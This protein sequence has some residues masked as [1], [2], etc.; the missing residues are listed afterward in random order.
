M[1][2]LHGVEDSIS[3]SLTSLRSKSSKTHIFMQ[4]V[5]LLWPPAFFSKNILYNL[6]NA[7]NKFFMLLPVAAMMMT[8]SFAQT[9]GVGPIL[10]IEGGQVQGIAT[11]NAG[12]TVYKGIPYAA[13]P[14]GNLR[15]KEPQPVKAW[16]GVKLC[17]RF[18]HPGY[19]SVHYPGGY[20]T[21]WGYGDEAPYSEDCLYLN[22]YTKAAGNP[23]KK[24]PVAL[25][26]HGG[27]YM[28]GWGTEPE[29]DGQEWASKDVV[30]VTINYRLGIFG[31]MTHPELS[32]ES[33]HHVSG[34]YGILDQI[35]SLKWIKANIEKFGGDSNN[36]TIFGQSAGAGSVRTICESPLA[37]GLFH[38]A[39]IMSGGGIDVPGKNGQAPKL[40]TPMA[41]FFTYNPS[42]QESE[43]ETKKVM[44]WAGLTSLRDLRK[45]STEML[46]SLPAIYNRV[47]K[48]DTYV[49]QRPIVDGYVSLKS[50]DKATREGTIADVP[51]MIGYTLNDMGNMSD[52]IAEFCKVRNAG[53]NKAWAYEFARPLP[54]DGSMPE[55]SARLSG[56]FHSSDLWYVFKSL[57][58]CW[59][60]WTK[61]DWDLSEKMLTAWTNFAKYSNP[62]GESDGAWTPCTEQSPKFM[63]FKLDNQEAEASAMGSPIVATV[64]A[65]RIVDGG[66]T[67]NYKALMMDLTSLPAHTVFAPKDLSKFNSKNP[68]PVLVWGNGACSNSP[69][70]HYRFLNEIASH[71]YL[72]IATG[73]Y[74][75]G[76]EPYEGE[77]S[78]PEQQVQSIDWAFA[79][80]K[81]KNSPF[82]GKINTKA[83]CAAG[84]SCGGLQTLFNCGDKRI[85]TY[86]IC[87]SGLFIDANAAIPG[88]PMPGKDQ[89]KKV[90]GPIM[91][92]LGGETDIAY[93]N[94]MD[95]FHRINNVPAIAVNYPVGHGGTY[96]EEFGGEFRF[97][98]V[99]WLNW[100]LK[101]DQEAAKMFVGKDCGILK[102]DKWTIEKNS[103]VK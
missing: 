13:P 72:V 23:G 42:L 22:V 33:P 71:G 102:R 16:K 55:V 39:V 88:M 21:E 24:L 38:K 44:D 63:L 30:L 99:A 74:P 60:P 3:L 45:A 84:M 59:R 82:F 15:W 12:V 57:K 62:N 19:Q 78:K 91:Y 37:R 52:G 94:G 11:D 34:N 77:M 20:A 73:F 66:G 49:F 17:D 90:H 5:T 51:Y 92:L 35:Q 26:I 81:D 96:R 58:H 25:W 89:L 98:A 76:D 31:F 27:G 54:D 61:G 65:Q 32:K 86:M 80:N 64:N 85:K 8:P 10:S 75:R 70:E 69:W 50:F 2:G 4:V 28:E 103:K 1:S 97:P 7:M 100:Q 36:V 29:F 68:L 56:A 101:K 6:I 14:I 93:K 87:N 47:N 95:D 9:K 67:G 43:A 79:Q 46:H 48:T 83:I 41:K 18:G 40:A 53:G